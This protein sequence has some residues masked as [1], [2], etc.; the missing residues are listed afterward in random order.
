MASLQSKEIS[1]LEKFIKKHSDKYYA[2]QAEIDDAT[3]DA[4]IN[5]LKE[6]DPKNKILHTIGEDKTDEFEKRSHIMP[7]GS[8]AKAQTEADLTKWFNREEK[9]SSSDYYIVNHKLDGMSIELQYKNG[10]FKYAVTRGNGEIGDDIT[11]NVN[12]MKGVAKEIVNFTG[13]VRGEIVMTKTTFDKK[14]SH[15]DYNRNI[16]NGIAK[17]IDGVGCKDLNVVVYDLW[18]DEIETEKDKIVFLREH[19]DYVA[20]TKIFKTKDAIEKIMKWYNEII[21][22]RSDLEIAIDGIVIKCN[23][24]DRQDF[25]RPKPNRQIAFKFPAQGDTTELLGVDWRVSGKTYTP[26]A[27]LKPVM[28]DGSSITAASLCN[29]GIMRA[30]GLRIGSIVAVT[31]RKDVIPKIES[32]VTIGN[33]NEIEIPDKCVNCGTKLTCTDTKLYCPNDECSNLLLHQ[34]KK[35]IEVHNIKE[36]GKKLMEM[37][38][39]NDLVSELADL[40]TLDVDVLSELTTEGGKR[41]GKSNAK[42]AMDNLLTKSEVSLSSFIAGF[43]ISGVGEK[44]IDLLVAEGYDTLKKLRRLTEDDMID[45]KGIGDKKAEL[46]VEGLILYKKEMDN[47]LNHVTIVKSSNSTGTNLSNVSVTFTG[48]LTLKRKDA[49]EMVKRKGGIVKKTVT[50]GLTYLVTADPDSGSKKNEEAIKKGVKVISEDEFIRL[51]G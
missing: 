50:N 33:G 35:W 19:F 51:F 20:E 27:R 8:L 47:M 26:V 9:R 24:V 5:K 4:A 17:R 23:Q 44:V 28:I 39:E 32:V 25:A 29:P 41:V 11:V 34:I 48:A 46:I 15:R 10:K 18:S 3:F 49:E 2:G 31:K 6:L 7:M 40:Y 14:Y 21:E 37:I 12:K 16:A 38:F 45:I 30:L 1:Q 43:D 13:A 42:K 22:T 36:F